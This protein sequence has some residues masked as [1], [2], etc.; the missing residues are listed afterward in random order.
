MSR[1][2]RALVAALLLAAPGLPLAVSALPLP[3]LPEDTRFTYATAAYVVDLEWPGPD[4]ALVDAGRVVWG[5]LDHADARAAI[6]QRL[7]IGAIVTTRR[8]DRFFVVPEHG[9]TPA[10]APVLT[11]HVSRAPVETGV[12]EVLGLVR[13]TFLPDAILHDYEFHLPNAVVAPS[14][15]ST[16]RLTWDAPHASHGSVQPDGA[17]VDDGGASLD[18]YGKWQAYGAYGVFVADDGAGYVGHARLRQGNMVNYLGDGRMRVTASGTEVLTVFT[19]F[20]D[21]ATAG[22]PSGMDTHDAI[23]FPATDPT[24][25][26][27]KDR[28]KTLS[29]DANAPAFRIFD[30]ASVDVPTPTGPI[31]HVVVAIPD[32]GIN[33]Y[34]EMYYRPNLTAHPC[35][36]VP[37]FPCSIPALN[38]S[39]GRFEKWE[40][41][42]AADA[43]V[44]NA[45][46]PRTWYW[47]PQTVFIAAMCEGSTNIEGDVAMET[48]LCLIDDTEMHGTGTTS[49]V[50]SENPNALLVF[51]EGNSATNVFEDGLLPIDVVSY[52]WG[53]AVPLP[54]PGLA[55]VPRDYSPFFVAA[56]GNEGAFPV[57]LDTEKASQAVINVGAADAA[58][59]SEPGYTGWKTMDYVSQ[60]CRPTA[61]TMTVRGYR[62]SFCGTSFAA[63]TVAGA[64]SKVILDIRRTSGYTG[65]MQGQVV[66]PILGVTKWDVR[67]ALNRTATYAPQARFPAAPGS[68]PLVE[69][70]PA[71]QWG[72]GYVD[73]GVVDATV[74]CVLHDAC[75]PQKDETTVAYMQALWAFRDATAGWEAIDAYDCALRHQTAACARLPAAVQDAL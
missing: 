53:A 64:L 20:L 1:A 22:F 58:T 45:T 36:Y 56:S 43:A 38:L 52:S 42:Y 5:T 55:T 47:I 11:L 28:I 25:A 71:Y 24:P 19:P 51:K 75:P 44:W 37:G 54:T 34:H 62:E 74:A 72:W 17:V 16:T 15:L 50:L 69:S 39:V 68:V 59:R 66:D 40:D 35:T 29:G 49:S 41:A 21:A 60:Y 23:V 48:D 4:G 30:P 27:F 61:D 13:L 12:T 73:A 9:A 32:S 26:G 70:A 65:G 2:S 8:D 14:M 57:V 46:Q 3:V 31:P 10:G 7:A 33:P 6:E 67:D 63:P 18:P